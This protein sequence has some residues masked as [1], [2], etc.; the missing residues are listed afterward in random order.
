[1][2]VRLSLGARRSQLIKQLLTESLVFAVISGAAGLFLA[3]WAIG[4]AN[5]IQ[6][7]TDFAFDPDLRLSVPVLSFTLALSLVTGV[8][9]GLAPALQSTKPALVPALK[10]AGTSGGP[11]SRASRTLVVA[12]MALSIVLLASAGLFLR[13]IRTAMAIDK[14]FSSENLLLAA[15]DPGLQGYGRAR[16]EELYRRLGERLRAMPNVR[17]VAFAEMVPLSLS[18]QQRGVSIPGYTPSPNENLSIDYNVVGADYFETMGIPLLSGRAITAADDSAAQGAIVVNEQF[19]RR[20]FAG[21]NPIGRIV[22]ADDRDFTVVGLVPNGKYRTL[23]EEPRAYIYF[24]QAQ[25]WEPSM[26]VHVRTSR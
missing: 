25:L 22:E 16:A 2:A 19:A 11:R 6:L 13:N 4:L 9:F 5:Q 20:F 8:V 24:P 14:G 18:D 23:G 7:P 3:W 10:G 26:V 15:I 12:Q 21:A 17:G 1:M